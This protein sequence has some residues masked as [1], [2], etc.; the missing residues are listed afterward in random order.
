M[1]SE[2]EI[3]KLLEEKEKEYLL[4]DHDNIERDTRLEGYMDALRTVLEL[5]EYCKT[6]THHLSNHTMFGL[7]ECLTCKSEQKHCEGFKYV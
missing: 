1:K 5:P 4:G 2:Q 3:R 6:C 7:G